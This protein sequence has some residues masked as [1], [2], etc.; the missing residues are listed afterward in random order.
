MQNPAVRHGRCTY[1]LG[2]SAIE[3]TSQPDSSLSWSTLFIAL[4]TTPILTGSDQAWRLQSA[5]CRATVPLCLQ[6]KRCM[7]CSRARSVDA[8]HDARRHPG[9]PCTSDPH[10]G[11]TWLARSWIRQPDGQAFRRISRGLEWPS[12]VAK[13]SETDRSK[14][15]SG[16]LSC[17]TSAL[18]QTMPGFLIKLCINGYDRKS[19]TITAVIPNTG[20]VRSPRFIPRLEV[21]MDTTARIFG[22]QQG[23]I[24]TFRRCFLAH[25]RYHLK[26][27]VS[28]LIT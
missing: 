8:N 16:H 27:R 20:K 26:Y 1:Y 18:L 15:L 14:S 2:F 22:M 28:S 3:R 4:L 12:C 6:S 5:C 7:W 13:A 25:C 21:A 9:L 24:S 11:I 10:E 17:G 23:A 19:G